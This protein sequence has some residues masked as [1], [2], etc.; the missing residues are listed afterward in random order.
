M[1]DV[2]LH[3]TIHLI[4]DV[5]EE[6]IQKLIDQIKMIQEENSDDWIRLIVCSSGGL[7]HAGFL[8]CD[9]V[10]GILKPKLQTVGLGIVNS[11]AVPVFLLGQERIVGPRATIY[12]H[13]A[14]RCF[15]KNTC[16][17]LS[18]MGKNFRKL[19]AD[20]R[21]FKEFLN[22]RTGLSPKKINEIIKKDVFFE[23]DELVRIGFATEKLRID[24]YRMNL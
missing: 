12:L 20:E 16:S 11:M 13:E 17:S 14:A 21:R 3:R 2:C 24:H 4:G 10:L 19:E 15:D 22:E 5:D 18:E 6:T 23:A 9:F 8:F 1:Q 7:M